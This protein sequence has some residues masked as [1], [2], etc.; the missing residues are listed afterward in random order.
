[1]LVLRSKFFKSIFATVD[2]Q[3]VILI[4]SVSVDNRTI[5]KL[6]QQIKGIL[7]CVLLFLVFF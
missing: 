6:L 3:P 1:M 2:C 4:F 5:F 7:E